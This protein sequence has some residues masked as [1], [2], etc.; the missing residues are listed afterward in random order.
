MADRDP[1]QVVLVKA[2]GASATILV[3]WLWAESLP[4]LPPALAL[5]LIGATGYGLSLR[6][7]L[8]AQRAFGVARTGSVFAFAPFI[9][10]AGAWAL[11]RQP[12]TGLMLLGGVLMATGVML[13]LAERHSH[14][15]ETLD[16]EHAQ[17]HDDSHHLHTH[18]SMP[19]GTHS[20]W[21]S[22][23]SQQHD[24]PHVPDLHHTHRH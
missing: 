14:A 1:G 18:G 10:A 6:F 5:L 13:Q 24:H 12:V 22:H 8:L 4:G 9:G 23:A 21:H 15:H 19:D 2:L 16:H 3:A 7:Y 20:H 17:R 11:G